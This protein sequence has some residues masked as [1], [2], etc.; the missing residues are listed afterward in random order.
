MLANLAAARGNS[1]Q[2]AEQGAG[3]DKGRFV[4]G[5][6][7]SRDEF[8]VDDEL[9]GMCRLELLLELCERRAESF[10]GVFYLKEKPRLLVADDDEIDFSNISTPTFRLVLALISD[11]NKWLQFLVVMT[12]TSLVQEQRKLT[13]L[14]AARESWQSAT[15]VIEAAL[16]ACRNDF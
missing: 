6:G 14:T 16:A 9:E 2:L 7:V 10:V 5:E 4:A 13:R 11:P 15:K 8:A 12:V 3:G 1:Q